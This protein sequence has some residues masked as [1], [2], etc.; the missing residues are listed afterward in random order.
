MVT[1]S[2]TTFGVPNSSRTTF[3]PTD[4][5]EMKIK[6]AMRPYSKIHPKTAHEP[7]G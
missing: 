2:F 5:K 6:Q 1:P 7:K 3:L 4:T